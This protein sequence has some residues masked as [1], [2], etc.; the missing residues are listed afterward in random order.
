MQLDNR[1]AAGICVEA[2]AY[3]S[4]STVISVG[5]TT[6]DQLVRKKRKDYAFG[7]PLFQ[8]PPDTAAFRALKAATRKRKSDST[9][10]QP[11]VFCVYG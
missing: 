5:M 8:K 10:V 4:G 11:A 9:G 6:L 3:D 2:A 7:E 1:C